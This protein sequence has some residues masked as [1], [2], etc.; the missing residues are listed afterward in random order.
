MIC[1]KCGAQNPGGAAFCSNCNHPMQ[2]Q[3]NQAQN[4]GQSHQPY[5]QPQS[6]YGQ[7]PSQYGQSPSQYGQ[8]PQQG[9]NEPYRQY[10]SA[11]PEIHPGESAAKVSLIC[12]IIGLFAFGL[13]VGIFAVLQGRK[14]KSLGY[15]GVKA[16]V[17]IVLGIIGIVGWAIFLI[18]AILA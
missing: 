16:T 3:G 7:S 11:P 9:S 8:R 13:I 14:A 6:Q 18:S 12:G 2:Q 5:G 4:Y 15:T 10:F 17:G 1:Q